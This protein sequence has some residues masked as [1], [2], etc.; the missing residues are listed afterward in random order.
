MRFWSPGSIS[1]GSLQPSSVPTPPHPCWRGWPCTEKILSITLGQIPLARD[2]LCFLPL[3]LQ[4]ARALWLLLCLKTWLKKLTFFQPSS[5]ESL[6]K[7][8]KIIFPSVRLW[9]TAAAP[10]SVM[11][12]REECGAQHEGEAEGTVME[13]RSIAVDC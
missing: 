6:L 8:F 3:P 12:S 7:Q 2:S 9:L 10:L 4:H 11:T 5:Q 13:I 1:E